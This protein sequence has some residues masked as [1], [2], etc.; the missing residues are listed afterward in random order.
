MLGPSA[1][2]AQQG[3]AGL[4]GYDEPEDDWHPSRASM[5]DDRDNIAL[6]PHSSSSASGVGRSGWPAAAGGGVDLSDP[7][8]LQNS[9]SLNDDDDDGG[10]Q[11]MHYG[12]APLRVPRRNKTVKRVQLFMGHLILD[13]PV[14]SRLLEH[15]REKD[16]K[17]FSVMRYTAATCDPDQFRCVARFVSIDT[18]RWVYPV[19]RDLKNAH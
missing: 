17:E 3:Y 11:A 8:V 16:E 18:Q 2:Q 14:P 6:L 9:S 15:A 19:S 7:G 5:Q 13:C 1:G 12:Q 4:G 10:P